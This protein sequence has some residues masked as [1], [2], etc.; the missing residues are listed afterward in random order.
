MT[1][2]LAHWFVQQLAGA[3]LQFV[4]RTVE[5]HELHC[6]IAGKDRLRFT[7]AADKDVGKVDKH[8]GKTTFLGQMPIEMVR[9]AS[10]VSVDAI[11]WMLTVFADETDTSRWLHL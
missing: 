1:S 3:V 10:L 7:K 5:G 6:L 9:S 2:N 4:E 11:Q 8:T